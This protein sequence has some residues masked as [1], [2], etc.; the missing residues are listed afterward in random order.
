M[1]PSVSAYRRELW[2]SAPNVLEASIDRV[3]LLL[4]QVGKAFRISGERAVRSCGLV[5]LARIV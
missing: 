2:L 4:L 3:R 1:L 5:M